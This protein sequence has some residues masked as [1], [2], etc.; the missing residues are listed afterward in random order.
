MTVD[1]IGGEHVSCVRV[2]VAKKVGKAHGWKGVIIVE[3]AFVELD[4]DLDDYLMMGG[5]FMANDGA[6]YEYL[7]HLRSTRQEGGR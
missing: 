1:D 7:H 3:R 6:I 4:H 5:F 2:R